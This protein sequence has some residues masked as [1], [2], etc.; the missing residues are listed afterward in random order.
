L[1]GSTKT[2]KLHNLVSVAVSAATALAEI[3]FGDKMVFLGILHRDG[4]VA[5]KM[6][7]P[8]C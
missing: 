6:A 1:T 8:T 4:G 5:V 3:L 7:D 2:W